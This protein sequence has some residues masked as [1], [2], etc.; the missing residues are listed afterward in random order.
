VKTNTDTIKLEAQQIL[1]ELFAASLIPFNLTAQIV[2]SIGWEEYIVRFYDS[3]L[4]SI[5]VSWQPDQTFKSVFR[6]TILDRV[7]RLKTP[8]AP[9]RANPPRLNSHSY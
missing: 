2:E 1:D 4:F 3:R 6:A 7:A 8:P 5:D 9:I